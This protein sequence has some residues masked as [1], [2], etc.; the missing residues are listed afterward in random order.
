VRSKKVKRVRVLQVSHVGQEFLQRIMEKLVEA[1]TEE[2]NRSTP[3]FIY[4]L[5]NDFMRPDKHL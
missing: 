3:H 1:V 5:P 2:L 4:S